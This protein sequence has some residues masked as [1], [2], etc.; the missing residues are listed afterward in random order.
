MSTLKARLGR[1]LILGLAAPTA[2]FA[3]MPEPSAPMPL[4]GPA[5]APDGWVEFCRKDR[6]E[7]ERGAEANTPRLAAR[8]DPRILAIQDT[9]S[10]APMVGPSSEPTAALDASS[11]QISAVASGAS[12][13]TWFRLGQRRVRIRYAAT[14]SLAPLLP[15][16]QPASTTTP[17][18]TSGASARVS[19]GAAMAQLNAYR[20][21]GQITARG[22]TQIASGPIEL[23]PELWKEVKSVNDRINRA[24]LKR[25]D[26]E[27]Y[28]VEEDWTLPLET[29]V[30]AGDCEDFVLEK[31]R[32]LLNAGVPRA[33]LSIAVVTTFRGARHAVLLL[34]T[35][36]GD[37]VLDSLTPWI[38]PWAKAG[39]HWEERQVAG[40]TENWAS[41]NAPQ[42]VRRGGDGKPTVLL[43]SL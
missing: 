13:M 39:Y 8:P 12:H 30:N 7:C 1:I 6:F 41:L 19:I 23:T 35:D 34:S 21:D 33:A 10:M 36:R 31:R 32:A 9:L 42:V 24:I 26:M 11:L 38:L 3:A 40:S 17:P 4:G 28:G 2:A 15:E 14:Y 16:Q 22:P 20:G 43:I 18:S 37:Y 5:A 25:S 27:L 29:G